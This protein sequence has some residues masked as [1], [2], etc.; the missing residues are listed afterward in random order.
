MII[1]TAMISKKGSSSS[2][3]PTGTMLCTV[4]GGFVSTCHGC[5]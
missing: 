2:K 1:N 4:L 5:Q 3:R